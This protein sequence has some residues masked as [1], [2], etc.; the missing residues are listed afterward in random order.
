M[1]DKP[2]FPFVK[3]NPEADH[4]DFNPDISHAL[5]SDLQAVAAIADRGRPHPTA[6]SDR[7]YNL[8]E[9]AG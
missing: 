1:K 5:V 8:V 9:Y 6:I 3:K 2:R 4:K 7:G